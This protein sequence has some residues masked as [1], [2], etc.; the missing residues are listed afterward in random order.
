MTLMKLDIVE[1]IQT[2]FGFPKNQSVRSQKPY[3]RLLRGR[4]RPVM[5]SW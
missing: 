3:L 5:M 4:S 1:Q 2:Q